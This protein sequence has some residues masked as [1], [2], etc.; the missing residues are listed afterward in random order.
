MYLALCN[1]SR[2]MHVQMYYHLVLLEGVIDF[3]VWTKKNASVL[4]C[5]QLGVG[6]GGIYGGKRVSLWQGT[7]SRK[8]ILKSN[9]VDKAN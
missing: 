8:I 3:G 5:V 7:S 1:I 6:I 4:M 9:Y 2:Y